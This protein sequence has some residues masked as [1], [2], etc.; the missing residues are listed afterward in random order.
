MS[1][2]AIIVGAG[3]GGLATANLLAK[4]GWQV[5][6][7]EQHRRPGGRAGQFS[8]QGFTFDTGPS[9]YLMPE[10]FTQYFGLFN[11]QPQDY[12]TLRK[13]DPAYRV[14]FEAANPVTIH[15]QLRLDG[16]TFEA[17]E[18]GAGRALEAYLAQAATVYDLAMDNF[19]YTN[20]TTKRH[21][22]NRSVAARLPQLLQ[23]ARRSLHGEVS[24]SFKDLRLQQILEYPSVF[25]GASP[26]SAPAIYRLMSHLDFSQGVYY[27]VGGLYQLVLALESLGRE[28]GVTYRYKSQ[29]RSIDRQQGVARHVRLSTGERLTAEVIISNADRHYTETTLL[30]PADRTFDQAYWQK[31]QP[32]PS[33]LLMF[34]GIK[35]KLPQLTHHN[36]LF[37][38]NWR[39]N[40]DDI[41]QHRQWPSPASMY[42]C[43]P[44][45]SD[46]LVAPAGHQNVFVLVPGPPGR[47]LSPKAQQQ[48]ADDYIAQIAVYTGIKDLAQKI[49][50]RRIYGPD[51]FKNSFFAWQNSALGLAHTL[52]QSAFFR[53]GTQSPRLPGLYFVGGDN[54]PGIGLPM[55]LIGAQLVYKQI[56]HL[57]HGR[58][59]SPQ[60]LRL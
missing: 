7:L 10:V 30:K 38:K 17:I 32:G 28:L 41:Y 1:R 47:L 6:V 50:F 51:Y 33:A 21:L 37:V 52:R 31:R 15:G 3:V 4:A 53:P 60:E 5:T 55:C 46:R 24:R 9:W 12:Y 11:R 2:R 13:L 35:G 36:L 40:F 44:S 16:P 29:V 39:Q 19:L 26:F 34:L 8:E 57:A 43:M 56:N 59:L 22:L 25:L 45:Y 42:V 54:L 58:P 23:A 49:V 20:F 18:P 27:P 14:F 48:A